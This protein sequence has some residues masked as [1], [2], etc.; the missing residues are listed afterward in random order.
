MSGIIIT[1]QY[2]FIGVRIIFSDKF[3]GSVQEYP[4]YPLQNQHS[5]PAV[6]SEKEYKSLITNIQ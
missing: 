4:P 3:F 1:D 2:A 5:V 6:Y